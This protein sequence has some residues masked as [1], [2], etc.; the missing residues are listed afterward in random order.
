MWVS[1]GDELI[2]GCKVAT[3]SNPSSGSNTKSR[4]ERNHGNHHIVIRTGF[5]KSTLHR[6]IITWAK[7]MGTRSRF[8]M[9]L[10]IMA[11]I[12]HLCFRLNNNREPTYS[13]THSD[14]LEKDQTANQVSRFLVLVLQLLHLWTEL[15]AFLNNCVAEYWHNNLFSPCLSVALSSLWCKYLT[16]SWYSD[17]IAR[18]IEPCATAMKSK[19]NKQTWT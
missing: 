18:L 4:D 1:E 11:P 17:V 6:L 8:K 19:Q 9:A 7:E 5:F 13:K 15:M 16:L 14:P 10:I 2:T 12:F 3:D